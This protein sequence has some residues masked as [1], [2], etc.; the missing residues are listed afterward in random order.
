MTAV[1]I[2]IR[3]YF[4]LKPNKEIMEDVNNCIKKE[5]EKL[6]DVVKVQDDKNKK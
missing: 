6:K 1:I 4:P 5:E 3:E 2:K